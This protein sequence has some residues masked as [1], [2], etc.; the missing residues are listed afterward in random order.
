MAGVRAALG[1]VFAAVWE[2]G[3]LLTLDQTVEAA[4]G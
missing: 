4:L 3:R 1:E 2:A